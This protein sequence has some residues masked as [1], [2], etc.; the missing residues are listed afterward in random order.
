MV[1]CD[2]WF[3]SQRMV[4]GQVELR[5]FM[6]SFVV[7]LWA[8]LWLVLKGCAAAT[9]P[10]AVEAEFFRCRKP[11]PRPTYWDL[12]SHGRCPDLEAARSGGLARP[13]IF[14]ECH[15]TFDFWFF[16]QKWL[17]LLNCVLNVTIRLAQLHLSLFSSSRRY[18]WKVARPRY[19]RSRPNFW[20]LEGRGRIFEVWRAAD[21]FWG[22]RKPRPHFFT[23]FSTLAVA[24]NNR[25]FNDLLV[26]KNI[27]TVGGF[28]LDTSE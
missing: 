23:N 12:E 26:H 16:D 14:S 15:V 7:L 3:F 17:N 13:V 8:V 22:S 18:C 28:L 2:L 21:E 9:L 11:R 4:I 19:L 5:C 25:A 1:I 24:I 27:F 6:M 10:A 20:D